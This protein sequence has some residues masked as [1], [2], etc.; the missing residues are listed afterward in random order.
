MCMSSMCRGPANVLCIVPILVY[1][2]P[3]RAPPGDMW[4]CLKT[5]LSETTRKVMMLLAS[6]AQRPAWHWAHACVLS[7]WLFAAPWTVSLPGSSVHGISRQEYWNGLPF[8]SPGDLPN[9]GIDPASPETP[10]LAG[11]FFTTEPLGMLP[12]ILQCTGQ[13]LTTKIYLAQNV[14]G[15]EVKKCW[16]ELPLCI[17]VL[18]ISFEC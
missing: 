1:V 5:F 8:P 15:A 12:N 17:A 14:K 4:Q 11:R 2:L 3:K 18:I 9:T 16:S 7:V 10:A 13:L 6:S